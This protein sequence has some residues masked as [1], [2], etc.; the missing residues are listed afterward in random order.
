MN[1]RIAQMARE[2]ELIEQRDDWSTLPKPYTDAL[3]HFA[4]LVAEDC[5][6]MADDHDF[7]PIQHGIGVVIRERYSKEWL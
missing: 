1:D 3:L 7:G 4:R 5:A 6:K 2:A